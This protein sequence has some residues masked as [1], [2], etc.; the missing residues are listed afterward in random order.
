M[1]QGA[2]ISAGDTAPIERSHSSSETEGRCVSSMFP[3]QTA[4]IPMPVPHQ[5]QMPQLGRVPKPHF[6]SPVLPQTQ[7][8]LRLQVKAGLQDT[9]K[10]PTMGP[11]ASLPNEGI[12]TDQSISPSYLP[13]FLH[14]RQPVRSG[15]STVP[16][17]YRSNV[18]FQLSET[19][20]QAALHQ[21]DPTW[22]E[23]ISGDLT[24][25]LQSWLLIREPAVS[26]RPHPLS[27]AGSRTIN[28]PAC[29]LMTLCKTPG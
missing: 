25:S 13:H 10:V 2:E 23:T 11:A 20:Q 5:L 15:T 1:R 29:P 17:S 8:S 19:S 6:S 4:P 28:S 24:V 27:R 21:T 3:A 26:L 14:Q 9:A 16:V 7:T 22:L 18:N 12:G